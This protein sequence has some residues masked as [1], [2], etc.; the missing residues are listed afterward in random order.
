MNR[1]VEFQTTGELIAE[2]RSLE[3]Y[4]EPRAPIERILDCALYAL[5][6]IALVVSVAVLFM[7]R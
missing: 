3:P 2:W 5:W 4:K 7:R 6:A 1:D